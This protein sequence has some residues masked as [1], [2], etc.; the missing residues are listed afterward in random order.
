[1]L[2]SLS[3]LVVIYQS[4]FSVGGLCCIMLSS[5]LHVTTAM[6]PLINLN[7]QPESD[8]TQEHYFFCVKPVWSLWIWR[9][10]SLMMRYF[11]DTLFYTLCIN[12]AI[13][14]QHAKP[15][16]C[17]MWWHIVVING[18]ISTNWMPLRN[19]KGLQRWGLVCFF[20]ATIVTAL[21]CL[22]RSWSKLMKTQWLSFSGNST[23][24]KIHIYDSSYQVCTTGIRGEAIWLQS[25]WWILLC[26][27]EI[28]ALM[29]T[30]VEI[31]SNM[32]QVSFLSSS[33]SEQSEKHR[34][35]G[36]SDGH[37]EY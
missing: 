3:T 5:Y 12:N 13:T 14:H 20:T 2:V 32:I 22:E 28:S 6:W 36:V 8:D 25:S 19:R 16:L 34:L 21:L 17:S 23:Q 37:M 35:A 18:K 33:H 11:K 27:P 9:R 10:F 30:D 29:A 31:I 26:G 4:L 24:I 15:P 1:M 7:V